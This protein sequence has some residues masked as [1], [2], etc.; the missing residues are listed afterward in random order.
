M[1]DN[2][3]K[4][5]TLPVHK[6]SPSDVVRA[7]VRRFNERNAE[8]LV[9]LYAPDAVN[10]QVVT[11]SLVGREAI[12]EHIVNGQIVLPR[13]YFDQSTLF[14]LQGLSVPD[15]CLANKPSMED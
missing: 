3:D 1:T 9:A 15:K 12:H 10:H 13:G 6:P 11:E 2:R 5:V 4:G 14:Q 8:Q 7:W